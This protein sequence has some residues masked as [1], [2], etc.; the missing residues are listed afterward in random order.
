MRIDEG[1]REQ[2]ALRIDGLAGRGLQV[3]LD[4]GDASGLDADIDT[5]PAWAGLSPSPVITAR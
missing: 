3:R 1:R 2:Q 4:R 5:P